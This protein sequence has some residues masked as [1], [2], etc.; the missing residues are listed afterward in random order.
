MTNTTTIPQTDKGLAARVYVKIERDPERA[1]ASIARSA[2]RSWTCCDGHTRTRAN[3]DPK[4]TM[5]P[6]KTAKVTRARPR[7]ERI[8]RQGH[9][10]FTRPPRHVLP[11]SDW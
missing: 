7:H 3:C 2:P 1:D 4:T 8:A 9:A 6:N 10:I 5:A 11:G